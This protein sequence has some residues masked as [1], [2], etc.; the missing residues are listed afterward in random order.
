MSVRAASEESRASVLARGHLPVLD[1]YRAVAAV[2]V[3]ATHVGYQTGQTLHGLLGSILSRLDIGVALFFAL[4]GF[5]LYRPWVVSQMSRR[6]GPRIP[7]YLWRRA[8]RILPAYW[9]VVVVALAALPDNQGASAVTWVANL[10]LVQIY[11][12][13]TLTHGLT[14]MWSLST[15]VAFYLLLPLLAWATTKASSRVSPLACAATLGLVLLTVNIGWSAWIHTFETEGL[16]AFWLP[17]FTSWFAVGIM[18]AAIVAHVATGRPTPGPVRPFLVLADHPGAC[19][20][21]AAGLM[22]LASTPLAGPRAFEGVATV[23]EGIAKN[24]L[25]AAIVGLVLLPATLGAQRGRFH[26]VM[27]AAPLRH[28]GDIS[29]GIFLWHLVVLAAIFAVTDRPVFSG[30]FWPVLIQ[31][32]LGAFALATASWLI[33]ERPVLRLKGRVPT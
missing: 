23:P 11:V 25:Y 21:T 3:V 6:A 2:A 19:W 4:S 13:D 27:A 18:L 32:L 28:L 17:N 14:Q 22:L 5:L 15:E 29:Y 8:L 24:L 9:V 7:G 26:S 1:A 12:P 31:T 20:A 33:L 16:R 30:G 10:G